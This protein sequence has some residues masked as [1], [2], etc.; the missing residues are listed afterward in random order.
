[1]CLFVLVSAVSVFVIIIIIVSIMARDT[2]MGSL[3]L[4]LY[5]CFTVSSLSC[6]TL[7]HLAHCS[8]LLKSA[9]LWVTVLRY[10]KIF[11]TFFHILT[12]HLK[13]LSLLVIAI[14]TFF[15]FLLPG[16]KVLYPLIQ[17]MLL[18]YLATSRPH[19]ITKDYQ[20]A[21]PRA[22]SLALCSFYS[23]SVFLIMTVDTQVRISIDDVKFSMLLMQWN[24]VWFKMWFADRMT[25]IP[26]LK[27]LVYGG[28]KRILECIATG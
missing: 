1:M 15:P 25:Q 20:V 11:L 5:A 7:Q 14:Q 13:L 16:M 2:E 23:T 28:L 22:V 26:T 12:P 4:C 3:F 19:K 21:L 10:F 8:Y 6:V 27:Q 17:A 18:R 24:T 9:R